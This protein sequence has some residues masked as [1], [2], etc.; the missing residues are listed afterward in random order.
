MF[1]I[2]SGLGLQDKGR[3][4]QMLEIRLQAVIDQDLV[5]ALQ[6]CLLIL[7][8]KLPG[9]SLAADCSLGIIHGIW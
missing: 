4:V 8:T 9:S 1:G 2:F 7:N 3:G 6:S 5:C